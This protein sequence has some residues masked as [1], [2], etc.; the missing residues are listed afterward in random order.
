MGFRFLDTGAMYRS[1]TLA[2]IER[3]V[4]LEDT[5]A[6]TELVNR[7]DLTVGD[8]ETRMDGRDVTRAIR[9]AEV[10]NATRHAADNPEVRARLGKLQQEAAQNGNVVTEGRDQGSVVFPDAECKIFLTASEEIRAERRYQDMV[11]HGEKVALEEVLAK[12]RL[13]DQQDRNRPA[14]ALVKPKNAIEVNTDGLSPAEVVDRLE[15][16]VRSCQAPSP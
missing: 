11:K 12:Q 4:D 6:M 15:A 10:T 14:G 13:R 5:Q 7:L 9:S 3:G 1:V 2:A 8:N 16:I